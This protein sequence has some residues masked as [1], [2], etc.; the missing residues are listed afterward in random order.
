[1]AA[2]WE[3]IEEVRG[4]DAMREGEDASKGGR[5]RMENI[6]EVGLPENFDD[7]QEVER[8]IEK[9]KIQ[10]EGRMQLQQHT[11]NSSPDHSFQ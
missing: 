10:I 5:G 9:V 7:Q 1:M 6:I 3:Y 4:G 11:R 8:E 2:E